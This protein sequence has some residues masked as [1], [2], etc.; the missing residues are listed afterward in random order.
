MSIIHKIK[1]RKM[2]CGSTSQVVQNVKQ[3]SVK[4]KAKGEALF[5]V[6]L[7]LLAIVHHFISPLSQSHLLF[8]N[9]AFTYFSLFITPFFLKKNNKSNL[10]Y[11]AFNFLKHVMDLNKKI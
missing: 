7:V 8:P 5:L 2:E 1:K 6:T 11:L 3:R 9:K 10:G 4:L